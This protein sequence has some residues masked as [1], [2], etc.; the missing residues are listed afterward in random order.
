MTSREEKRAKIIRD[1]ASREA[2]ER[3]ASNAPPPPRPRTNWAA[4]A[5][6]R[7]VRKA[8]RPPGAGDKSGTR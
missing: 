7:F 4:S 6:A 1:Q 5:P 3:A 2:A 8:A